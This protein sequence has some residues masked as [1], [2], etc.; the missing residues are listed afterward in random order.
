MPV[1]TQVPPLRVSANAFPTSGAS[2][3]EGETMTESAITPRVSSRTT[4]I[5]SAGV[6]VARLAPKLRADFCLYSTGSTATMCVAPLM[7]AP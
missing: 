5:A 2:I 6:D 3:S 7:R 4:S 1:S